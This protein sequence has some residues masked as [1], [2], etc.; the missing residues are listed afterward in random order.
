MTII[1]SSHE[2]RLNV[3]GK[4]I[5]AL[6]LYGEADRIISIMHQNWLGL[7]KEKRSQMA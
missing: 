3:I 1:P 4:W 7:E 5:N 6:I 2:T